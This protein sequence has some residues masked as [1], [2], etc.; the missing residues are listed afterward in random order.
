[1]VLGV[2]VIYLCGT[3]GLNAG[4]FLF[5]DV[6]FSE[7]TMSVALI[8]C[9]K[10]RNF[11]AN[12]LSYINGIDVERIGVINEAYSL[13]VSNVM[14]VFNIIVCLNILTVLRVTWRIKFTHIQTLSNNYV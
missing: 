3:N 5:T 2:Y 11:F 13:E 8:Y 9:E 12:C 4:K 1:M 7:E 14:I 10:F 6:E